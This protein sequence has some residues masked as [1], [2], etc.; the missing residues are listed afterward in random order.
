MRRILCVFTVA[1]MLAAT[2]LGAQERPSTTATPGRDLDAKNPT[3]A[4]LI[5]ILPGA[6]HMYAGEPGRGMAYLGGV[7]GILVI[8]AA[9][10]V[11]DCLGSVY[12]QADEACGSHDTIG[13]VTSV[14]ALGLWGWSIYD[15]GRAAKRTN[16]S[17]GVRTSLIVAPVGPPSL[18]G[19]RRPGVTLGLSFPTR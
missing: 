9:L 16:A 13:L 2:T 6:G 12:A 7:A 15:A 1:S 10:T 19:A 18:G 14:A 5:G 8:G 11:G 17:R 4:M 3:A